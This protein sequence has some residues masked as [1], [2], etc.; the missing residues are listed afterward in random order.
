MGGTEPQA[1]SR[2][3]QTVLARVMNSQIQLRPTGSVAVD[4]FLS[5]RKL[6]PC[7]CLNARCF[8]SSLYATDAFQDAPLFWS[9]KGVS[10]SKFMCGFFKG[11]CLG[12]ELLGTAEVTSTYSILA[13]YFS[14]KVLGLMFLALEL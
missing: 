14:Q 8:S 1:I 7:S 6:F 11:N 5:G 9:S 4:L 10:L 3:W 2:A 13:V 12:E